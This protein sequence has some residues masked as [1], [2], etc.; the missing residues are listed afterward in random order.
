VCGCL[1]L[2][3]LQVLGELEAELGIIG[4]FVM[5]TPLKVS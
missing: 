1:R 5:L 3:D 4:D 2:G